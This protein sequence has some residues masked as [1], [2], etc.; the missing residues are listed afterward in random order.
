MSIIP[1]FAL[2]MLVKETF[3]ACPHKSRMS[4]IFALSMLIQSLKYWLVLTMKESF[5]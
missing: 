1:I 5:P 4:I 3:Q 2:S